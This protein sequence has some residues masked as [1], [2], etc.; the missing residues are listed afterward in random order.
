[1]SSQPCELE[2]L[3]AVLY[4][5]LPRVSRLIEARPDLD[6]VTG[7]SHDVQRLRR[8]VDQ[9]R[10]HRD[11]A[12]DTPATA[13]AA[14][15]RRRRFQKNSHSGRGVLATSWDQRDRKSVV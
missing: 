15:E 3:P 2:S 10:L 14:L 5:S 4:G 7:A 13:I 12:N 1:M 8:G 11:L 9:R 6:H